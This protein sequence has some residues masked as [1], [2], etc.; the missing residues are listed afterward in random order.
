MSYIIYG[1][2]KN[3]DDVDIITSLLINLGLKKYL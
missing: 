3:Y 1:T 2:Q